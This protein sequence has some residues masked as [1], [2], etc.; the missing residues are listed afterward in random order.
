M[1]DKVHASAS[2]SLWLSPDGS[3]VLV[4][5]CRDLAA[6]LA[7]PV[8]G[9]GTAPRARFPHPGRLVGGRHPAGPACVA[10]QLLQRRRHASRT[11]CSTRGISRF[12]RSTVDSDTPALAAISPS[13]RPGSSRSSR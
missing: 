3:A 10:V 7:A 13:V 9:P 2:G 5:P 4:H 11:G 1:H 8:T 6:G 12:A